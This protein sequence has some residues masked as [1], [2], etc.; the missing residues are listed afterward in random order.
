MLSTLGK[1]SYGKRIVPSKPLLGGLAVVILLVMLLAITAGL[2]GQGLVLSMIENLAMGALI[3]F[4][5]AAFVD[6]ILAFRQNLIEIERNVSGSVAVDR[7]FDVT[8]RIHHSFLASRT[9]EIFDGMSNHATFE[10]LPAKVELKPQNISLLTYRTKIE[11]RGPYI[12]KPAHVKVPSFLKF[13]DVLYQAGGE[14]LIKVYPDFSA[15]THYVLLATDNHE[16]QIGIKRKPRRGEGLEFLQL[17]DYRNGD[18]LRKVDWKA[19]SRRQKIISKE[20]Q[21]ERDQNI[22]L[23]IDSGRRMRS[24]DGA[25][26]HFDHSL[27]AMLLV[28]YL[29]LRQ[30]DSVSVM[31]IGSSQR[32]VAPQKG[33]AAMKVI[34][35]AMYDLHAE[36]S[37]TDYVAAAERLMHVQRKRSLVILVTNTRDEDTDELMTA[38]HLI[39]R[40]HLLLLANIRETIIDE[41]L[42][43][44]LEEFED[45][46]MYAGLTQ[47]E[48]QRK[49]VHRKIKNQGVFAIDC[50]AKELAA[51]V[52]NSYLE[53]KRAGAL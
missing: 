26:S 5:L 50:V 20:Y 53:I 52:A 2:A 48:A 34:L 44:D 15:I 28:S 31:D 51:S 4:V 19:T 35:N 47:F 30:G 46:V 29:A 32:W 33:L 22:V 41:L 27:N 17:R 7:W 36:N 21:D 18:S 11:M 10:S 16:S 24:R 42:Q 14:S 25:L 1:T 8:L 40:R 39:K 45:A 43:K 9:I 49:E 6:A 38:A 13:W 23:L 12:I 37:A 3:F